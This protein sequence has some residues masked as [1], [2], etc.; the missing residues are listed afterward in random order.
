[1]ERTW[2]LSVSI[3][4]PISAEASYQQALRCDSEYAPAHANLGLTLLLQGNYLEGFREYD[5]RRKL[6]NFYHIEGF[7]A[8]LWE[9]ESLEGRFYFTRSRVS[10][11]RCSFSATCRWSRL[12]GHVCFCW[13]R[14][15]FIG[16]LQ[17]TQGS[18]SA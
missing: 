7:Q 4:D 5:W 9:G 1:M 17:I 18:R 12:A 3:R 16:W 11:I 15:R 6:K 14:P 13:C 8:P 10:G 2:C